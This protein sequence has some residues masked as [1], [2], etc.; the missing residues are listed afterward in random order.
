M[1]ELSDVLSGLAG[2][3][4]PEGNEDKM[5]A[6]A[7]GWS[8]TADQLKS[9]A[10]QLDA[11]KRTLE[12]AY[13]SGEG[14]AAILATYHRVGTY[15]DELADKYHQVGSSAK[16]TGADIEAAKIEMIIAL[17]ALAAELA[18]SFAAGP[19]KPGVDATLLA[20]NRVV[21]MML[22]GQLLRALGRNGAKALASK[23][24]KDIAK[25]AGMTA[26]KEAGKQGFKQGL[27]RLTVDALKEAGEEVRE[28]LFQT[29]GTKAYQVAVGHRDSRELTDWTDPKN[30][31]E[32]G[33]TVAG[34]AAGGA[35]G[36]LT[37][38]GLAK[39]PGVDPKAMGMRG[40]ITG[41]ATGATAGAA[42]GLAGAVVPEI[43]EH[44]FHPDQWNINPS[45]ITGGA[46]SGGLPGAVRG[47]RGM[48]PVD[49]VGNLDVPR[50]GDGSSMSSDYGSPNTVG[51]QG[52]TLSPGQSDGQRGG[53]TGS[54]PPGGH[55]T[56]GGRPSH[57]IPT[58]T[59]TAPGASAAPP[60]PGQVPI[61]PVAAESAPSEPVAGQHIDASAVPA[62]GGTRAA[63]EPA[64][65]EAHDAQY[66]GAVNADGSTGAAPQVGA[67][68]APQQV[69]SSFIEPSA[70]PSPVAEI[71]SAQGV[72]DPGIP[73]TTVSP[74]VAIPEAPISALS[75]DAVP[76][77][78]TSEIDASAASFDT[79]SP[80][81]GAESS[82]PAA[83]APTIAD[84]PAAA[85]TPVADRPVPG[86]P[87]PPVGPASLG[88]PLSTTG[89]VPVAA[90]D[91]SSSPGP[92]H[93]GVKPPVSPEHGTPQAAPDR[94]VTAKVAP[95]TALQFTS[96][97]AAPRA[98]VPGA[99]DSEPNLI[100]GQHKSTVAQSRPG[101]A[102]DPAAKVEPVHGAGSESGSKRS[103]GQEH[104]AVPRDGRPTAPPLPSHAGQSG[105]APIESQPSGPHSR[106][107]SGPVPDA[108][109]PDNRPA[110]SENQR[111]AEA[112]KMR[113]F[114]RLHVPEN[115]R[116][117][118]VSSG[119]RP[120]SVPAY[121]FRRFTPR[122]VGP[123]AVLT[124]RAHTTGEHSSPDDA[125]RVQ[126]R[127]Q[128]ATDRAFNT[129][130]RLLSGDRLVVDLIFTD[131][132]N[133]AHLHIAVDRRPGGDAKT[134]HPYDSP[135][136]ITNHLRNHLGLTESGPES[137]LD[138][139]DLRQISNDICRANTPARFPDLRALRALSPRRLARLED[140][141]HQ[142]AVE[143][144][145]RD[146]NRFLIGADPRTNPYGRLINDGGPG[147]PGRSNNCLDGSVCAISSFHGAP[148][149]A[150]PRW[151]DELPDGTINSVDGEAGGT[152]RATAWLGGKWQN[153]DQPG[154]TV[155][156]QFRALHGW[157]T[158]L[159]PGSSALLINELHD[160]DDN[161][162]QLLFHPDGTPQIS[163]S[164][165]TVI[166]Y[167]YGAGGPVWWD[168]QHQQ[169]SDTPPVNLLENS[170]SLWFMTNDPGRLP[171]ARAAAHQGTSGTVSGSH[172]PGRSRVPDS[173]NGVRLGLPESVDTGRDRDGDGTGSGELRDQRPDRSGNSPFEPAP[174]RDR[175]D[176]RRSDT[177]GSA[178]SRRSGVPTEVAREH[179]TDTGRP[180]TDRIPAASPVDDGS[181]GTDGPAPTADRQAH[182]VL[183]TDG[184]DVSASSRLGGDAQ[185][186]GRDLAGA[187]D[188]RALDGPSTST[189]DSSAEQHHPV[190]GVAALDARLGGIEQRPLRILMF[191]HLADPNQ[192]GLPSVNLDLARALAASGHE[193]TV[194]VGHPVRGDEGGPGVTFLGPRQHDP[195]ID[196]RHQ[197]TSHPE[198]LPT[199]VDVVVGHA[200]VTGFVAREIRN[201]RYSGAT[202][203]H[204]LH[205][206][207]ESRGRVMGTPEIGQELRRQDME[208]VRTA[209]VVTALGPALI[210]EGRELAK[211]SGRTDSPSFHEFEPGMHFTEQPPPPDG[212]LKVLLFGRVEAKE[213]GAAEAAEIVRRLNRRGLDVEL[214][215]RGAPP[216]T[217]RDTKDLLSNIA[218]REVD[219]R[220]RTT[221]RAEILRD[222]RGAHLFVM[223]SRAESFGLVLSEAAGAGIPFAAP[224][225]SGSG[226]FFGDPLR[227]P[228]ELVQNSLVPQGF[229][230]PV[231]I[232]AWVDHL[233]AILRNVPAS[234]DR[235]AQLQQWMRQQRRTW[236]ASGVGLVAT[237]RASWTPAPEADVTREPT[238]SDRKGT[239]DG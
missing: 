201:T 81:A 170:A 123:L 82:V 144:A 84:T 125:R 94:T 51:T 36:S 133:D 208:L 14:S 28:E 162:G 56:D 27:K 99:V 152:E 212:P 71:V 159:G 179:P 49:H 52:D 142:A 47:A 86:A 169:M 104:P 215:V 203:V 70:P 106:Q 160:R 63:P 183:P 218:D 103:G 5:F 32:L 24:I 227:F 15:L 198:D 67:G 102:T 115:G 154:K 206:V 175:A 200:Y 209:D 10:Q 191:C 207:A 232:D 68:E 192:G 57:R 48:A 23:V 97:V 95:D 89:P 157:V 172:L 167:P 230:D 239:A 69:G 38:K 151:P 108:G 39:L 88:V 216:E 193:V 235:A 117:T 237:I 105:T 149:V 145:L 59:S 73:I 7:E 126:N 29:Y 77:T 58:E 11:A 107:P 153:Y 132:P 165:A 93:P 31:K 127:A 150:L 1:I 143:D 196:P 46:A 202:L 161:T 222:L 55:D 92:V 100:A 17:V 213:K 231:N 62:D 195:S 76:E 83:L 3:D 41:L 42:G 79:G 64:I 85:G 37:G 74:D 45:A 60:E 197:L 13:P 72:D 205:T 78:P 234:R 186:H 226:R 9:V 156:E 190:E 204:M 178:D 25:H 139:R 168:P 140:L 134:W 110:Q 174:A 19:F 96:G 4:W 166:V 137:M 233:A 21:M 173:G 101:V 185:P 214:I 217:V 113:E 188:H 34:A 122:K 163:G 35:T 116:V 66:G 40:A 220:P 118:P 164:H 199:E 90:P 91:R 112:R 120:N 129:G 114:L 80:P 225:S 43:L 221:D 176:V 210:E 131:D 138:S 155:R 33:L 146:G 18:A 181:T 223:T 136:T 128:V 224:A 121:E 194:R 2:T 184:L 54:A 20:A 171:S 30:L 16:A 177:D 50:V 111:A 65:V 98:G 211:M 141:A 147:E 44:G 26:A 6:L 87:T 119:R 22:R 182:P 61:A 130:Q 148:L 228:P 12:Q 109:T 124:I 219:V 180:A 53:Q 187:G 189:P 158:Y 238:V 135:D 236:K 8:H 229:E 75:P